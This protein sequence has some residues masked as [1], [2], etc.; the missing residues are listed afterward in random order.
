MGYAIFEAVRPG[1]DTARE[2][3]ALSTIDCIPTHMLIIK[4]SSMPLRAL[5]CLAL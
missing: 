3:D 1:L 5:H 2:R 4:G